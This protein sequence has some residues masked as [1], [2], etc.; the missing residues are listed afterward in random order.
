MAMEGYL[1]GSRDRAMKRINFSIILP[2]PMT[3]HS[4]MRDD[5]PAMRVCVGFHFISPPP[6][7]TKH[8]SHHHHLSHLLTLT[9]RTV[10]VSQDGKWW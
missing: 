10:L 8:L 3:L 2:N 5:C 4:V 1:G 9:S 6:N 7:L